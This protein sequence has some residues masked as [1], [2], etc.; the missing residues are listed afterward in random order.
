MKRAVSIVLLLAMLA[1]LVACGAGTENPSGAVSD[2]QGTVTDAPVSGTEG[3]PA[4]EPT[5]ADILP[6]LDFDG[7]TVSIAMDYWGGDYT[8]SDE[9]TGSA[10]NDAIVDRTLAVAELY[11]VDLEYYAPKEEP[12]E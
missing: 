5:V 2:T 12:R 4:K 3:E 11:N 6:K 8:P 7:A 10:V 9:L 1:G